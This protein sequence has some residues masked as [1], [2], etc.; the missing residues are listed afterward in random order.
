M[1][2]L[3]QQ[4]LEISANNYPDQEAVIY[5][6]NSITYQELDKVANQLAH[7]L[8]NA[9]IGRGDRVGICLNKSIEAV[10]TIYG[11]MKAGAA[12]VPIDPL[13]PVKRLRFFIED[14]ELKALVTTKAKLTNL[15]QDGTDNFSQ[16][17]KCVILKDESTTD[18]QSEFFPTK[19][20]TWQEVLR[21]PSAPLLLTGL[22]EQDLATIIYTSG[23]TGQPK[24]VM[25]SHRAALTSINCFYEGFDVQ[26]S[27]R[28][29][30]LFPIYFIGSIFDIFVPI[31]AGATLILVPSEL[32]VLPIELSKFTE[33]QRITMWSSV[34]SL[35]TQL[36]LRGNLDKYK[37]SDLRIIMF[38]GEIFPQKYLHQLMKAIPHANYYQL[39]GS[40]EAF[41]RTYYLLESISPEI[42]KIPI[43]KAF[44]NIDLFVVNQENQI[45]NPGE[46]GEL[47]MRGSSLMKGYWKMPEKT[48]EVLVPYVFNPHVGEEIIFRTGDIVKQDTDGNYI[49]VGR[50]DHQIKSRG[51]RIELGE[52]ESNL[53]SHPDIEEAVVIAIPDEQIN[54]RIEAIVVAKEGSNLKQNDLQYFCAERLPKYMIPENIEFSRTSLPKTPTGKIDRNLLRTE[55]IE[56]NS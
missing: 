42:T 44:P 2:Y 4:V 13:A 47:C 18:I 12:Y 38:G 8:N 32:S 25:I 49:Y 45:V 30:G 11:I 55:A 43:G 23:S 14:C 22:I 21:S 40:T 54:N 1:A 9:G 46:S 52:I 41:P 19:V 16:Y 33:N 26:P 15:Y 53:Y 34:S 5:K 35:L 51:Y 48:K 20:L 17:L 29:S 31:Q 50:R 7:V 6:N 56:K 37:F 28:V 24:G 39:Y 36:V 10:V 3:L 27:D